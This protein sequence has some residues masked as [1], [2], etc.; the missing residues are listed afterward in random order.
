MIHIDI[1]PLKQFN[2]CLHQLPIV[3][4][5]SKPYWQPRWTISIS[6]WTSK[7]ECTW[8]FYQ[9]LKT[10]LWGWKVYV[11]NIPSMGCIK[12]CIAHDIFCIILESNSCP[13]GVK[14]WGDVLNGRKGTGKCLGLE[15]ISWII[16]NKAVYVYIHSS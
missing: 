10:K 4:L 11:Q 13:W 12:F 6:F 8:T 9:F 14:P 15:N 1:N 3:V 5:S 7:H 16:L 2:F